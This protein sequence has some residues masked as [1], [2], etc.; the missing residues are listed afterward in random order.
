M[1]LLNFELE[2]I[3][4][5]IKFEYARN[6]LVRHSAMQQV[7]MKKGDSD[8]KLRRIRNSIGGANAVIERDPFRTTAV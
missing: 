7:T 1:L 3:R 4:T 2:R 8:G 6:T 5:K